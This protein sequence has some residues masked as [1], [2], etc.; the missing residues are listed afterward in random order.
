MLRG[1][2]L[3]SQMTC[4]FDLATVLENARNHRALQGVV[5]LAWEGRKEGKKKGL[6]F[7][8]P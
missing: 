6:K 3:K 4:N 7:K 2:T 8:G 5:G 1:M